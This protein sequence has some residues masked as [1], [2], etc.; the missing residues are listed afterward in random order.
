M[1]G[2]I[3]TY[4][5]I[6]TPSILG[7]AAFISGIWLLDAILRASDEPGV[8]VESCFRAGIKVLQFF[9]MAIGVACFAALFSILT[10]GITTPFYGDLLTLALLGLIGFVL[11]IAP[12]AKVP[13][14]AL[15]ALVVAIIFSVLVALFTPA[16]IISLI[17]FNFTWVLIGV[18]VIIGIIVFIS[19]KWFEELIKAFAMILASRP[20]TLILA[21]IGIVQAALIIFYPGGI[22]HFLLPLLP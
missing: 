7:I 12:I 10:S 13:W 11:L 6:L 21:F 17:P 18:F 3:Q 9:G 16:W 5:V 1:A 4:L 2:P 20:I 15:V 22:L 14:A 19:L 8:D